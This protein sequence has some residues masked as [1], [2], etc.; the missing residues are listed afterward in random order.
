LSGFATLRYEAKQWSSGVT[1]TLHSYDDSFFKDGV[2]INPDF[3]WHL[4]KDWD[5]KA[6]LAYDTGAS[7]WY[8]NLE[9]AWSKPLGES[10]FIS[11][12]FGT[13]F[14]EDYYDRS[15]WNDIYA[16]LGYT[17]NFNKNVSVTPF[18]G[19]SVATKGGRDHADSLYAGVWFEV[20]F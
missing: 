20:N 17:Y 16:R 11:T 1:A 5:L 12:K 13:S 14:V 10:S 15:G 7:G 18:V 8:G 3:T 6:G 9:A 19:T 2:D 4:T